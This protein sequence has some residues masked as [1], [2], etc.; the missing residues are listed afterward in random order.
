M[1]LA[2]AK[3]ALRRRHHRFVWGCAVLYVTAALPDLADSPF[4][5]VEAIGEGGVCHDEDLERRAAAT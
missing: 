2:N 3:D 5:E 1:R 4:V